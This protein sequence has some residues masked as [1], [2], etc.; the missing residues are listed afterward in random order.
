MESDLLLVWELI[1][2]ACIFIYNIVYDL[3][4]L[5]LIYHVIRWL[6]RH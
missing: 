1:V 3:L 6:R 2:K 5:L 4:V